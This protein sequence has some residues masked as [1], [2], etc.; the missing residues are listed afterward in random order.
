[1]PHSSC[2]RPSLCCNRRD[3]VRPATLSVGRSAIGRTCRP[4]LV[5]PLAAVSFG[6]RPAMQPTGPVPQQW[7]C[8]VPAWP[9]LR[10]SEPSPVRRYGSSLPPR[11]YLARPALLSR[12][13][14]G[15]PLPPSPPLQPGPDPFALLPQPQAVLFLVL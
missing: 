15:L 5:A 3:A 6:R 12:L 4:Q 13:L 8:P 1:M 7:P 9:S 10:Q 11:P 2:R 14:V